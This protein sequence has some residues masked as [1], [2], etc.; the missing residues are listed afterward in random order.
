M[1]TIAII[2]KSQDKQNGTIDF[3]ISTHPDFSAKHA[4]DVEIGLTQDEFDSYIYLAFGSPTVDGTF[5]NIPMW[6]LCLLKD[7]PYA[8]LSID[9]FVMKMAYVMEHA[10]IS[11][12]IL[13]KRLNLDISGLS[14][15]KTYIRDQKETM[16]R[17]NFLQYVS[18]FIESEICR[19]NIVA[20][21]IEELI[22]AIHRI[23]ISL[24]VDETQSAVEDD[25]YVDVFSFW[26][27][28]LNRP[29]NHREFF[30]K[31]D[32]FIKSNSSMHPPKVCV[33]NCLFKEKP[34][35]SGKIEIRRHPQSQNS[36]KYAE[37]VNS[38]VISPS[39]FTFIQSP[40]LAPLEYHTISSQSAAAENEDYRF[41]T[42][43]HKI[44][45][46]HPTTP[47]ANRSLNASFSPTSHRQHDDVLA[48]P[49]RDCNKTPTPIS[50]MVSYVC[51]SLLAHET[52][53][54]EED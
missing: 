33:C 13:M 23:N 7:A 11:D 24:H 28:R 36:F 26:R 42:P 43:P 52:L 51:P 12:E 41:R 40:S 5:K 49:I 35:E 8:L 18:S 38:D 53:K 15:I 47:I 16:L 25:I 9:N 6:K 30:S 22:N 21:S 27:R 20:N 39:S 46:I 48:T 4:F 2:I 32:A 50:S 54:N 1:T 44:S 17:H 3:S 19:G 37:P 29:E 14:Y 34:A 31:L 45:L 10:E